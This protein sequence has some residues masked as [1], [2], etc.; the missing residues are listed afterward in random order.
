MVAQTVLICGPMPET[1]DAIRDWAMCSFTLLVWIVILTIAVLFILAM[2][3]LA[4]IFRK[5]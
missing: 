1:A 5:V 2:L 3:E 4:R